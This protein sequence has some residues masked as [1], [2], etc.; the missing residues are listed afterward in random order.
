MA[1]QFEDIILT[2]T[3]ANGASTTGEIDP[4][5]YG[6][7]YPV[8][9][10]FPAA[11]TSATFKVQRE[12]DGVFS[13][14]APNGVLKNIP[15]IVSDICCFTADDKLNLQNRKIKLVTSGNEGAARS[16]KIV[17]SNIL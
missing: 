2:A 8:G 10:L 1:N 14:Y 17:Y 7:V 16:L 15:I 9:V 13:D 12:V 3:V 4:T 5:P 6:N 11:M